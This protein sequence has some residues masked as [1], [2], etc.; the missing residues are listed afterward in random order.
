[1]ETHD[2]HYI[3]AVTDLS[4]NSVITTHSDI[5]SANGIKVVAA[6]IR[7]SLNLYDR[8]VK[9]KLIPPLDLCLSIEGA[10]TNEQIFLDAQDMLSSN[11]NKALLDQ[12]LG[13]GESYRQTILNI[14]FPPPLAFKLTVA[15]H[16]QPRIYS[17]SLLV[18]LLSIF[19]ARCENCSLDDELQIATAGL[20]HEIGMLHIDPAI[21]APGHLMSVAER[22]HLYAHP[23]TAFLLLKEI[24]DIPIE[25]ANAILEHHE[26]VDGSGYPRGLRG[27]AISRSGQILALAQVV[28]RAFDPD[29][30]LNQL[31]QLELMLKL[32]S[33]QY[34]PGLVRH[35]A[36]L[37]RIFHEIASDGEHTDTEDLEGK[38][39]VVGRLF[40]IIHTLAQQQTL[41]DAAE[42]AIAHASSLGHALLT[43]G[44]DV[45]EPTAMAAWLASDHSLSKDFLALMN[46][47]LWQFRSLEM[48]ILRRWPDVSSAPWATEFN[49]TLS[50]V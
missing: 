11:P 6:G 9:H 28:A 33:D 40:E 39:V 7:I 8:L 24:P 12:F 4:E 42:F 19:F 46:E 30:P 36:P 14:P 13:K 43:A 35:L 45:R 21:L 37:F 10:L 25:V 31:K 22:K 41:D 1:M 17:R 32:N 3:R 27:D 16:Q 47:A 48:Q 38:M 2:S 50:T 15:K 23:L 29:N 5:F 34:G 20:F 49:L 44:F 18:T 26:L